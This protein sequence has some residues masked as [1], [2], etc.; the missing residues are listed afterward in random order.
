MV[1]TV[2]TVVATH[3]LAK[4]VIAGELSALMF[5]RKIARYANMTSVLSEDGRT[6]TF[7]ATW[8]LFFV[9]VTVSR[10]NLITR[11]RSTAS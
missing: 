6:R 10:P 3:D 5:T 1:T 2:A 7:T 8:Q 11:R 9:T 4:G